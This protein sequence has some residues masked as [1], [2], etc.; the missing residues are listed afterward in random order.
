LIICP[1]LRLSSLIP[2]MPRVASESNVL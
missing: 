2:A 1:K